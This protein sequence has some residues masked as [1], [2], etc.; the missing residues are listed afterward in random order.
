MALDN[1]AIGDIYLQRKLATFASTRGGQ[2]I[3]ILTELNPDSPVRIMREIIKIREGE[4]TKRYKRKT[5]NEAKKQV[6]ED[7]RKSIKS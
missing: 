1:Q 2:E 3:S 4:F 6:T 7:I 5:A